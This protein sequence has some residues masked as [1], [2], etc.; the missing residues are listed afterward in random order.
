METVKPPTSAFK[1]VEILE[2]KSVAR[3]DRVC[4]DTIAK[5]K[6]KEGMLVGSRSNFLFLIYNE[7]RASKFTS[8]RPF[9]VNAGA[10]HSYTLSADG[11]TKYLSELE[12]GSE[13]WVFTPQ[14]WGKTTTVGRAKT[15]TRPMLLITAKSG[16]EIGSVIVQDAETV[17]LVLAGGGR[18]K[19]TELKKGQ[20]VIACVTRPI[21]RHFGND[22]SGE[23]ILEK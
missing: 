7:S 4:V 5:L 17:N 2:I 21:G 1:N 9:R 13:I 6:N 20:R 16:K 8:A 23:F 19:V 3:G 11:T 14:G 10:V 18:V 15:E 12:A 22:V